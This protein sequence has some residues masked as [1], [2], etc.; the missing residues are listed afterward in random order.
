MRC[1]DCQVDL[2]ENATLCPLCGGAAEDIPPLIEGVT[3]QDYP[4]YENR[5]AAPVRPTQRECR[6]ER[7][8]FREKLKAVLH[9]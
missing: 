3:Y 9:F 4:N 6:K 5:K 7:L 1:P 8:P 2:N